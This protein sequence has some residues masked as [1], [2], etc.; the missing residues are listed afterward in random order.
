MA[1][2]YPSV[3]TR[4]ALR[5]CLALLSIL[6][7]GPLQAQLQGKY[8]IGGN[9]PDYATIN[10][11]VADLD[12]AGVAGPVTFELRSG[13][14]FEQVELT[15]VSGASATN[16]ITFRAESGRAEDVT[17]RYSA[18]SV[19]KNY[20]LQCNGAK[21]VRLESLT[22]VATG[23][24]YARAVT[25][26]GEVRDLVLDGNQIVAP[27]TNLLITEQVALY[28]DPE[29]ASNIHIRNNGIYGGSSGIYFMGNLSAKASDIQLAGNVLQ[30]FSFAGVRLQYLSG[31]T[32]TG[33][34]IIGKQGGDSRYGLYVN[35]WDGT[36]SAPILVANNFISLP[37]DGLHAV[38]IANS[39]NFDF[40]Y[41]S[42]L[43]A[44]AGTPFAAVNIGY[45]SAFNN[46]F[47]AATAPAVSVRYAASVDMQYNNLFS[48][49]PD[50]V[51]WEDKFVPDLTSWYDKAGQGRYS[52]SVDPQFASPTDLHAG[53]PA[54]AGAGTTLPGLTTDI[55][56]EERN[57]P[58]S[59]GAD[60]FTIIDDTDDDGIAD[61]EDNCP[62]T[63]NPDQADRDG[64]GV[65]DACDQPADDTQS[66]FWLEAECAA[67]GKRWK[68]TPDGEASN[69]GYVSAP[70]G[71]SLT[72]PPA[73]EAEN[74]LRFT[75]DR[76]VAG[77]YFLHLRIFTP[78]R[79]ADSFWVRINDGSWVMWNNINGNRKFSWATLPATLQLTSGSNTLDI[80][81][82]EGGAMLDKVFLSG[83][84]TV[85]T[86]FGEPASNC[87]DLAN[88]PPTAIATASVSQGIAP[89]TVLLDGSA[90]Y[91]TDGEIVRYDWSWAGG[92][93]SGA[94]P[95]VSLGVGNYTIALQ[96]TD[97]EG[98]AS[99]TTVAVR[100]VAPD[101]PP[102]DGPFSFEAECST[103]H[104]DWRLSEDAAA[105]GKQFV[106]YA[107]CRCGDHPSDQ[108]TDRY[109]NYTFLTSGAETYYLYLLL[110]A[111]DVGRNSLWIRMDEGEWIK[112][113]REE[114]G[115]AL[116]T[117]GFEWRRVTDGA[118]PVSFNLAPGEH[119]ITVA[120]REP[121]TKLDKLILST[122][123]E[124]PV[125]TG[126][127]A[128]DC[129]STLAQR[130]KSLATEEVLP[131][132]AASFT[133][134]MLSVFPNPT[135]DYLIVELTDGYTG[136][137][138]LTIVDG[139]GRRVRQMTYNKEGQVLRT[140]LPV[141]DL[142]P[143]VYYLQLRGKYQT[144][145]RFVKR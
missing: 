64:N 53:N 136:K 79:G 75:V 102:S 68:V 52:V 133:E 141:G 60:E 19:T 20:V 24:I 21:H 144:V 3:Y 109:L 105:S 66:E 11:A 62:E 15:A 76:A 37:G 69:Q 22:V 145:E 92:T 119:T 1:N 48:T 113:W 115:S 35:D 43:Q 99:T 12:S 98:K 104:A 33:N 73:D 96:V 8:T 14:Y 100:V 29:S 118:D 128:E 132:H 97:D 58:P 87:A 65:G 6:L 129:F 134:T 9:A 45:V 28:L 81:F 101:Q 124:A 135:V 55:D 70:G 16:T 57:D 89:L 78:D 32:F 59:I 117:N 103:R 131:S 106:S 13:N 123:E 121:G 40:H 67:V 39:D 27:V 85:P 126:A 26:V 44:K 114:N 72:T 137:V 91:D 51:E 38:Y 56:G 90:S 82:R 4:Y 80:A 127:P 30:E 31:G 18:R 93:A 36:S 86:G 49:G 110:D 47:R 107:G 7:F 111:P 63:F 2:L 50:L 112:V 139:L 120:P 23:G 10:A 83:E 61:N 143:G 122:T 34:R 140:E 95:T 41:N 84:N 54:L 71:R 77:S 5:S 94:T 17:I 42:L 116:L 25:V 125:G 74:R 108:P 142:S 88:Q 138:D 130:V 46:I